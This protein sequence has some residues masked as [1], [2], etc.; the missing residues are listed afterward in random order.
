MS[1][2]REPLVLTEDEERVLLSAVL[3]WDREG[4]NWYL[5]EELATVTQKLI[6]RCP[7]P[8]ED[9]FEQNGT[10]ICKECLRPVEAPR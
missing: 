7:H 5:T 10:W 4:L 9:Q 6:E 3:C 2:L 1:L 8:F